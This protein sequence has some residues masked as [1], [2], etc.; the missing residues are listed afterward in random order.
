MTEC[1]EGWSKIAGNLKGCCCCSCRYQRPIAGHPWN[2]QPLTK[3]SVTSIIGFGC[4][5]MD[6]NIIFF[7]KPHGMCEMYM[8]KTDNV[9]KLVKKEDNV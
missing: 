8:S 3:G 5:V 9:V 1:Y 7:D 4:T 2:T 6:G